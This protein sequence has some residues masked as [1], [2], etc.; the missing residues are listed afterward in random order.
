MKSNESYEY[1]YIY[2]Q[3]YHIYESSAGASVEHRNG[4][5]RVSV[6][7]IINI[8]LNRKLDI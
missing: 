6:F 1:E 3:I 8:M 7:P 5:G 2:T 4:G